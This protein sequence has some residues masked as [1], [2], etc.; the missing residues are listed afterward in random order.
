M[1]TKPGPV[2]IHGRGIGR[3]DFKAIELIHNG[4]VAATT[5]SRAVDGH[6]EA[7]LHSKVTL[8][9]P[10]WFALRIPDSG[11]NELGGK[12]ELE[13]RLFAHTSPIYVEM[14]EKKSLFMP[15]VAQGFVE[16][17][18]QSI[19]TISEKGKFESAG[20]RDKILAIYREGIA[21]LEKRLAG[22]R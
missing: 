3:N 21:T 19:A 7:T 6:F 1:I 9:G 5:K 20:D 2:L 10:G 16:D 14:A 15:E 4:R 17:M 18:R 8:N 12:N 13:A 22:T 11:K